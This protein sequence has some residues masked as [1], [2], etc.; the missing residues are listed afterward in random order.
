MTIHIIGQR[1]YLAGV[2]EA[3]LR[4]DFTVRRFAAADFVPSALAAD[5]TVINCA[6]DPALYHEA[7][8]SDLSW[9][10]RIA[11][12]AAQQAARYVMLSSRAVYTPRADPPLAESETP[13]PATMYG[14]N[15]A[16][17]ETALQ[18]MLG[19]RLLI[20]RL[21]NVFG[22]EPPGR[23]TFV[24]TALGTLV[25]R[26]EIELRMASGTR[27]DFLPA[28]VLGRAAATLVSSRAEG[29]FNIGSGI[30][31]PVSQA[32][33]ALIRGF[34][35]GEVRITSTRV[36][37]EFLLD[38]ARLRSCGGPSVTVDD[39]LEELEQAGREQGRQRPR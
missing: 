21:A 16:R 4:A 28:Y 25:A 24:S 5:D 7:V 38:T 34:G 19:D 11:T 3:R 9:D 6:F 10:G 2:L 32:A 35:R 30:A 33:E 12:A 27:K 1:S 18:A 20:L 14:R 26:G 23:A 8:A 36:G 31:L 22:G 37:E 29:I 17:I 15:K 13:A 39:L